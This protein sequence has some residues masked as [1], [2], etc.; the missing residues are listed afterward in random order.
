V[1]G[2]TIVC[3]GGQAPELDLECD[4]LAADEGPEMGVGPPP[5]EG[6]ERT[7]TSKTSLT[8]ES[9][10][11]GAKSAKVGLRAPLFSDATAR[12]RSRAS[13]TIRAVSRPSLRPSDRFRA[14]GRV[15][16]AAYDV[17]R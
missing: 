1:A 3:A 2:V 8:I 4:P 16:M 17:T 7:W 9:T 11:P 13:A 15:Q 14:F 5:D 6:V 10:S 12:M